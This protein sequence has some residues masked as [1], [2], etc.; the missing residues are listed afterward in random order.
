VGGSMEKSVGKMVKSNTDLIK[1][2]HNGE[3]ELI[4]PPK[5]GSINMIFHDGKLKTIEESSKKQYN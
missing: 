4:H 3:V 1:V 5:Y 2:I